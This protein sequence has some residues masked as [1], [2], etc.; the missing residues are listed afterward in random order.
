MLFVWLNRILFILLVAVGVLFSFENREALT[1]TI[2]GIDYTAKA[3]IVLVGAVTLG[4]AL[5]VTLTMLDFK[6]K[7]VKKF[8]ASKVK[9]AQ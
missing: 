6:A 8:M 4:F 1:F 2:G 5:G 3:Y 7:K 9:K